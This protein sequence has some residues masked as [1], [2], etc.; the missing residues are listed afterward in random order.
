M[1]TRYLRGIMREQLFIISIARAY[2]DSIIYSA[3]KNRKPNT[4]TFYFAFKVL[5]S[6]LTI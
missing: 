6:H 2:V 1:K 5:R 3:L 4:R